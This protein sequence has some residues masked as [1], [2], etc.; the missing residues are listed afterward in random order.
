MINA[1]KEI[2][3]ILGITWLA[4]HSEP[5]GSEKVYPEGTQRCGDCY[6]SVQMLHSHDGSK[7]DLVKP[8]EDLIFRIIEEKNA[9]TKHR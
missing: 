8:I 2:Q 3:K 6:C 1:K 4:P 5:V 9:R 7:V